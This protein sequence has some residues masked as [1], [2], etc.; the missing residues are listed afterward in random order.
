MGRGFHAQHMGAE[1]DGPVE[2]IVGV[3]TDSYANGHAIDSLELRRAAPG[4]WG[5]AGRILVRPL[6]DNFP[7]KM[8]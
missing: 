5:D 3:M 6:F 1:G 2:A 7:G 4:H 8:A